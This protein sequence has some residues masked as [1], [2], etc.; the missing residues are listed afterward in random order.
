MRK[1]TMPSISMSKS[2]LQTLCS[3]GGL[4]AALTLAACATPE[5]VKSDRAP[6]A[7]AQGSKSEPAS[8]TLAPAPAPAAT[9]ASATT[10]PLAVPPIALPYDEAVNVAVRDLF[11]KAQ[12]GAGQ[13]YSVVIDPLVDGSTGWQSVAT[14]KLEKN[15]EKLVEAAFPQF[16]IKPFTAANVAAAP[17]VFIGTFTPINLLGKGDGA[18]DA[19]RVCFAL[20][21]LKTGIIVSKGFARSQTAGIDPTPLPYFQDAPVWVNDKIVEGYVK[22]CQGTKAGDQIKSEYYDRISVAAGIDTATRAYNQKQYKESLALFDAVQRSPAGDQPRVHTGLY[23]SNM[24][25]GKRDAAMLAFSKVVQYGLAGN[26]LAVKFNFAPGS[27]GLILDQSP[28]ERWLKEIARQAGGPI[29]SVRAARTAPATTPVL[30]CFEIGGHTSRAGAEA[31]NERI[32]LQRAEYIRSKLV[33][34][35]KDLV[36]RLST[37]G[38]G[39]TQALVGTAKEDASD[40]L[41]RRIELKAKVC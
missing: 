36:S 8:I 30:S 35:R 2:Y 26:R 37:A 32:S 6:T 39:S 11:G 15:V 23:L 34:E 3:W 12:L 13:K 25:L 10:P 27:A 4:T 33:T 17:L 28:A 18:R 5:L 29:P 7:L 31:I 38:Y 20:A 16:E 14:A 9:V 21:D 1:S 40:T 41:D 22:T 19:Y 24:K